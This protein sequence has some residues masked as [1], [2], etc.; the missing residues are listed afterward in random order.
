[1]TGADLRVTVTGNDDPGA[2]WTMARRAAPPAL[3]GGFSR[4]TGYE[5]RF[6]G[7][8]RRREVPHGRVVF[9][10]GF[11]GK[12]DISEMSS[13]PDPAP[14]R[15]TSFVAG[16][17]A[18]YALV[19]TAEQRGIQLDLTPLAAYR[20]LGVPMSEL[21]NR[22]V[23]LEDLRGGSVLR[24]TERL[25][26]AATW[27]E[28]FA[29]LDATLLR[30]YDDGPE[31][32]GAVAWA[33][34]QLARSGG[35]VEVGTLA[36]EIGWSR[37][38][39]ID[40]FRRQVGLPPKLS[41]QV[42]RFTRACGLLQQRRPGTTITDVAMACGYADHSHLTREFQHLAGCTPSAWLAAQGTDAVGTFE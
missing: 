12:L 10:L 15:L 22:I 19:D 8:V 34:G 31:P 33:W 1:M 40:R 5:E 41:A 39:F 38:H 18:G 24:L 3:G 9:I 29:L 16:F 20:L 37:R 35:R 4:Y 28:R 2:S 21:A 11:D 42:L 17:H 30:W 6:V 27:E 25:G 23:P 14:G 36:D 7:G 26:A 32:D 13:S